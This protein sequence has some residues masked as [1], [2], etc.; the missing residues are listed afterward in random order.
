MKK[1]I[2]AVTIA[3]II[4]L[5]LF[6]SVVGY[7]SSRSKIISKNINSLA[8]RFKN[9]D[10]NKMIDEY[11]GIKDRSNLLKKYFADIKEHLGH[12]EKQGRDLLV[13]S[14]SPVILKNS[15]K[16]FNLNLQPG[17]IIISI[18]FLIL[19]AMFIWA[20]SWTIFVFTLVI[21]ATTPPN[22]LIHIFTKALLTFALG[23][24]YIGILIVF[25]PWQIIGI[26]IDWL[27]PGPF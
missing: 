18:I 12:T 1:V 17:S 15:I 21:I 14:N 7:H 9:L 2:L 24:G 27:F 13:Q 19:L 22:S 26:F 8:G 11:Q 23:I 16:H 3:V 25:L 6:P 10:V 20:A 5:A 4:V